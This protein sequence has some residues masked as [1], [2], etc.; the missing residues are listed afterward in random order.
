MVGKPSTYVAPLPLTL[1]CM[2][3][4]VLLASTVCSQVKKDSLSGNSLDFLN[5]F[6][7]AYGLFQTV[8]LVLGTALLFLSMAV[9]AFIYELCLDLDLVNG[10][11][12]SDS[13]FLFLDRVS[14]TS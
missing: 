7:Q 13:G 2:V 6:S 14:I 3:R 4:L 11:A 12:R 10:D 5:W 9:N 8:V 1:V